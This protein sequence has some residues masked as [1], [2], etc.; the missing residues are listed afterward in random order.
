MQGSLTK[1]DSAL[2]T[3]VDKLPSDSIGILFS[4][5]LDSALLTKYIADSG[6]EPVLYSCGIKGV[7][8]LD[9]IKKAAAFFGL[10]HRVLKISVD[11]LPETA[12]RLMSIINDKSPVQVGIGIPL[13]MTLEMASRDDLLTMVA[14][15]GADELFGGYHRYLELPGDELHAALQKDV[16]EI[17]EKNLKRDLALAEAV[18]VE[19][20]APYLD[21]EVI[22]VAMAVPP[23]LKVKDGIRKYILR[24]LG[25]YRG[26]PKFIYEKEKKAVQ[27]STGVDK[28]LRKLAKGEKK[29]LSEYLKGL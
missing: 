4:G 12:R 29:T 24:E 19:L 25:K 6:R 8:D 18:G 10:D 9:F 22:E 1:L 15:Q 26:L 11:Q 5:G 2:K 3:A 14:G 28:S 16:D 20:A 21:S 23:E 17:Y 7:G 13:F 27:Y